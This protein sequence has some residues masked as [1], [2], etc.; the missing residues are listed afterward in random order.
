MGLQRRRAR[1][2]DPRH[3]GDTVRINVTDNPPQSTGVHWHGVLVPNNMDDVPFLTRPPIKPGESFTYEF[4]FAKATRLAHVPLAPQRRRPGNDGPAGG[5]SS[6]RGP[7]TRPA[8][9]KEYTL[10]LNDGP[11][12]GFT[13][14]GKG[15][16]ATQPL[17]AKRGEKLLIRYM[18]EGLMI[19]P[20]HLHGMAPLV[21]AKDGY[22]QPMP[23]LCD[24]LNI[25]PGER[26]EV[27]VEATEVGAWAFHC[28]IVT[29]AE[30]DHGMSGMVTPLIVEEK[31]R[32]P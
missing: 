31:S 7:S 23:W 18:N 11:L 2:G 19:H 9:D 1:P 16:P 13:I 30:S 12:G 22:L 21:I 25:A 10:I 27:I 3:R 4:R 29:H 32:K 8:F 14:N 15:F 17:T 20:M 6:S 28:D 26:W 24:T 5:S